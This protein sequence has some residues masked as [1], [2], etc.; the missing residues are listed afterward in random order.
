MKKGYTLRVAIIVSLGGF[1]YGFDASVISGVIGYVGVLYDLNAIEQGWVVSAPTFAAMFSML[2][3]GSIS[4]SFGRRK[5]LIYVALLYAIS[6]IG[7]AFAWSFETLVIARMIGGMAFGAA[8]ILGPLYIA[9]I[10]PAASRGR[11]VSV[12][13]LNLVIGLS[14]AYFS[15]YFLQISLGS[16]HLIT[17]ANV[18]RWMLGLEAIPALLYFLFLFFVPRSPRWLLLKGK[19]AEAQRTLQKIFGEDARQEEQAITTSIAEQISQQK[20]TLGQLFAPGMRLVLFIGLVIGITQMI[21]GIN[22]IFFYANSIFEQSGVGTNAA[23][24]QAVLVGITFIVFTVLSMLVIDRFGRK[25]LLLIGLTG[26]MVSLGLATF[27]FHQAEFRLS[28]TSIEKFNADFDVQPLIALTPQVFYSDLDFKKAVIAKIGAENFSKYQNQIIEAA[29]DINPIIVLVGI[30]GFIASFAMSLGPV[31]WVL[32]SEIFPTRIRGL[33]I[34]VIGFVNSTTSTLVTLIF[35]WELENL[36]NVTTFLIYIVFAAIGL[37]LIARYLPE[38]KGKSL[39]TLE[40]ELI[41]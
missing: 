5:V 40:K 8:L 20:A 12:Q 9:E 37:L 39:E 2:T 6:A 17:E 11:L 10:S 28:T 36:G 34:S 1:L 33:A 26:V 30:L 41:R 14:A 38:T 13:Q 21:T 7:S 35:P 25:P 18:W 4:T 23:F 22:A 32:L 19:T 27:G 29:I 16:S 15:N 3:A 24:A 31:M